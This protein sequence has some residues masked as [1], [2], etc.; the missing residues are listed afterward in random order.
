MTLS[1]RSVFIPSSVSV[2]DY[3]TQVCQAE[4]AQA[5]LAQCE[6]PIWTVV[7]DQA[8][9]HKRAD[10][11]QLDCNGSPSLQDSVACFG[12]LHRQLMP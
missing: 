10:C 8:R 11:F 5:A 4:P 3:F 1:L 6:R 7:G 12:A 2:S 9:S